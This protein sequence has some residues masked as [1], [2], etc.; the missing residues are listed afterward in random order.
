M[1]ASKTWVKRELELVETRARNNHNSAMGCLIAAEQR[2]TERLR[3]LEEDRDR[4]E[5]LA[6]KKKMDAYCAAFPVMTVHPVPMPSYDPGDVVPGT[7]V[8]YENR[9]ALLRAAYK[10]DFLSKVTTL[11]WSGTVIDRPKYCR[12]FGKTGDRLVWVV[13]DEGQVRGCY[14]CNLRNL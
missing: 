8:V 4:R 7:R 3:A 14:R 13:T 9:E 1:I 6:R 5:A 2:I 11:R 12:E 10:P